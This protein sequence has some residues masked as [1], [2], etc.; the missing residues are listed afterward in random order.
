MLSAPR[1]HGRLLRPSEGSG[2]TPGNHPGLDPP[3]GLTTLS[4]HRRILLAF[5][6]NITRVCFSLPVPA[7]L[8]AAR[9]FPSCTAEL[10]PYAQSGPHLAVRLLSLKGKQVISLFCPKSSDGLDFTLNRSQTLVIA[11][12][13]LTCWLPVP[14][15][16]SPAVPLWCRACALL[17]VSLGSG[18][19][20]ESLA[21][22]TSTVLSQAIAHLPI[23][24]QGA[25]LTTWSSSRVP[26]CLHCQS[27]PP[28]CLRLYSTCCLL[29]NA[30]IFLFVWLIAH[31][32]PPPAL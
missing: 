15:P 5:L 8:A 32:L 9:L 2:R 31:R 21:A 27:A 11:Q 14:F 20:R 13:P 4:V 1:A 26:P 17:R 22:D 7:Q 24:G 19:C 28:Q 10:P 3:L 16:T 23:S 30:V 25:P 6:Q 12:Q 29:T 18:V